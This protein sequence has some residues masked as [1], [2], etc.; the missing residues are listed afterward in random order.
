MFDL[1]LYVK[2]HISVQADIFQF[3]QLLFPVTK[4]THLY[5]GYMFMIMTYLLLIKSQCSDIYDIHLS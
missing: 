1:H 2:Q 3:V 5:N 4:T